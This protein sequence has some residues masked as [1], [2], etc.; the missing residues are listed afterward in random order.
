MNFHNNY[1]EI[2]RNQEHQAPSRVRSRVWQH[3]FTYY[4][5][6]DHGFNIL[7]TRGLSFYLM[8]ALS[9]CLAVPLLI[10]TGISLEALIH[11]PF[12]GFMLFF[13]IFLNLL[14]VLAAVT[15]YKYVRD[16][17]RRIRFDAFDQM[18]IIENKLP[19][20]ELSRTQ[21]FHVSDA[22]GLE[23][24]ILRTATLAPAAADDDP[25]NPACEVLMQLTDGSAIVLLPRVA[26]IQD[27]RTVVYEIGGLTGLPLLTDIHS[28]YRQIPRVEQQLAD[29]DIL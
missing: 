9:V 19:W 28:L 7:Y 1:P 6:P 12:E 15:L 29:E 4:E 13:T 20:F 24:R 8:A 10:S 22:A 27:A 17:W 14:R 11:D 25:A 18:L 16:A 26:S 21:V 2:A 3:P 23:I 5:T